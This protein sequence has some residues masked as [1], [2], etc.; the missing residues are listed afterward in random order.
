MLIPELHGNYTNNIVYIIYYNYGGECN[1]KNSAH[2]REG[3]TG[4]WFFWDLI[5]NQHNSL[6]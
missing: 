6:T 1:K 5:I 4:I 2:P 3:Q